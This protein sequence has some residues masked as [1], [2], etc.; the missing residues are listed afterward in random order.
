MTHDKDL[1]GHQAAEEGVA[2][3][4]LLS[5]I[6]RIENLEEEK[7]AA[8]EG[9][10]EVLAEAKGEGFDTKIIRKIIALRKKDP[11]EMS[12]EEI[13]LDVYLKAIGMRTE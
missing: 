2:G 7:K 8:G 1:Q 9:V 3:E 4:R 10:K 5:F 11:S 12:E 6:E 13:M